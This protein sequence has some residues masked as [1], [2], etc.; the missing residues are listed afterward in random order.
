MQG[1][2]SLNRGHE[3]QTDWACCTTSLALHQ[4]CTILLDEVCIWGI[5]LIAENE[6]LHVIHNSATDSLW[7][8]SPL[9]HHAVGFLSTARTKFAKQVL[10]NVVSVTIH[11]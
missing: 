6:G 5:T 3:S 4:S 1:M 8:N 2:I 9:E 7:R 11:L 10:V